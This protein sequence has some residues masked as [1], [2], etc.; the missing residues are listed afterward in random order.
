MSVSCVF[1]EDLSCVSTKN[2]DLCAPVQIGLS[3]DNKL[4]KEQGLPLPHFFSI[5]DEMRIETG[6]HTLLWS[7]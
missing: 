1:T 4:K 7:V 3:S 2:A 5:R 6:V